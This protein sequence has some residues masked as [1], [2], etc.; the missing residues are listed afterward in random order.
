M[1][2][3]VSSFF[4]RDA[5]PDDAASLWALQQ[6]AYSPLAR[7]LPSRPTALDESEA[8]LRQRLEHVPCQVV[9]HVGGELVA[10]GRIEGV[11]PLGELKRIAVHPARQS[12][13]L[14]RM[15]VLALEE[16]ARQL[17]FVRLRAGT[18]RR[19]PGNVAFYERLGYQLV[20]VEPYPAGIDDETVW[21]EKRL[22]ARQGEASSSNA[23][24]GE[25]ST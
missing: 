18:R 20:A 22:L 13:G 19:L 10:A 23:N 1:G 24:G 11:A 15:L 21:L 25:P 9:V 16:K 3:S 14:G 7:V 5:R 17:E 12:L 4:T 6:A 8:Y 2:I